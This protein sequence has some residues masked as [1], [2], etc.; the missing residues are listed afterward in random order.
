[1]NFPP[2]L[3]I[4]VSLIFHPSGRGDS[5]QRFGAFFK[6]EATSFGPDFSD[7][8]PNAKLS[9]PAAKRLPMICTQYKSDANQWFDI[10]SLGDTTRNEA[11]QFSGLCD[12][13]IHLKS[14]IENEIKLG[15]PAEKIVLIGLSQGCAQILFTLLTLEPASTQGKPLPRLGAVVGMSGWLPLVKQINGLLDALTSENETSDAHR[16][17][18]AM[19]VLKHICVL[20][21]LPPVS[22]PEILKTPVFI[23]HGTADEK[24]NVKHGELARDTLKRLGFDVEWFP[25]VDFGHWYKTPEEIDDIINFLRKKVDLKICKEDVLQRARA[26]CKCGLV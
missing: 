14:L 5:A 7:L 8:L 23:G 18:V 26:Y 1:L 25:Y 21:T 9:F 3:S 20:T 24:V 19:N 4:E 10:E 2:T 6:L 22:N 17:N 15:I 13:A 11:I 12:S 16:T